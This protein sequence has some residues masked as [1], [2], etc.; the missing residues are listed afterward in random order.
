MESISHL[1][2]VPEPLSQGFAWL[3][4][5]AVPAESKGELDDNELSLFLPLVPS[6]L[7]LGLGSNYIFL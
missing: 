6:L 5:I 2:K 3:L 7:D 1:L 4:P